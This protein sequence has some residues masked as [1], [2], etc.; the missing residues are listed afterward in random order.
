MD[1]A[2][3]A[4]AIIGLEQIRRNEADQDPMP[5]PPKRSH[6]RWLA[7]RRLLADA[8]RGAARRVEPAPTLAR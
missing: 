2:A 5:Q 3:I 1:P 4:T 7:A 8:L 6:R